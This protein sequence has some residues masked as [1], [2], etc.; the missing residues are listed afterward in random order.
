MILQDHC[1]KLQF[2]FEQKNNNIYEKKK[3]NT[4]SWSLQTPDA[5]SFSL[6]PSTPRVLTSQPLRHQN[7]NFRIKGFGRVFLQ[8]WEL[9]GSWFLYF[10]SL[11][12]QYKKPTPIP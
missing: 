8:F 10:E 12:D 5:T 11:I 3:K 2:F 4:Y 1:T 6:L 7:G 9:K